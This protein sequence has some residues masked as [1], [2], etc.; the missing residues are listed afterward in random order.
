MKTFTMID[1][2]RIKSVGIFATFKKEND[3]I[4]WYDEEHAFKFII[5]NDL[6][7]I[8]PIL[9]HSEIY[10]LYQTRDMPLTPELKTQI[11]EID[12]AQYGER[13]W[14][15]TGAGTI[16]ANGQI[17]GWK[18]GCFRVETN[19]SLRDG[20]QKQILEMFQQGNLTPY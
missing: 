10:A 20:I 14:S 13:N 19:P 16:S 15:V 7:L 17:T 12:R 5:F 3:K 1:K 8:A 9:N 4:T 11:K 6:I 2:D 18:S